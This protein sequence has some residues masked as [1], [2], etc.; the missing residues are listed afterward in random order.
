MGPEDSSQS[1]WPEQQPPTGPTL[2]PAIVLRAHLGHR[3]RGRRDGQQRL[4][5]SGGVQRLEERGGDD[6]GM[7]D[8]DDRGGDVCAAGEQPG[9]GHRRDGRNLLGSGIGRCEEGWGTK[10]PQISRSNKFIPT[11]PFPSQ[12]HLPPPHL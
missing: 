11:V 5:G 3:V 4:G 8:A 6:G 7:G 10:S 12:K 9:V 1:P 2:V